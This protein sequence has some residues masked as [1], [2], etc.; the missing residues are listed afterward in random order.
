[1]EY[2]ARQRLDSWD[3]KMVLIILIVISAARLFGWSDGTS[4]SLEM[5]ACILLLIGLIY[6]LQSIYLKVKIN[7][8]GIKFRHQWWRSYRKISWKRIHKIRVVNSLNPS[9]MTSDKNEELGNFLKST[10]RAQ[11]K[12]LEIELKDGV[13]IFIGLKHP[14][15]LDFSLISKKLRREKLAS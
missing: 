3:L 15:K 1:M 7:R 13:K 9:E 12:G 11:Q 14:E 6:I 4:S 2:L 5:I 10:D 8:N